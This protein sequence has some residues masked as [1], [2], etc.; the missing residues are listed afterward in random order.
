V[1]DGYLFRDDG[2]SRLPLYAG[3]HPVTGDQLLTQYALE[4]QDMGYARIERLGYL[5][6]SWPVTGSADR[7]RPTVPWASRFGLEARWQ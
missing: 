7:T 2:P 4:A 3:V 1:P 6:A 5:L